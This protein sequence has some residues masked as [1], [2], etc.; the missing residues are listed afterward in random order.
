MSRTAVVIF[1]LGGPD[2]LEA[3][4]P[5]LFN[6][7]NDPLIIRQPGPIRWLI[8]KLISSRRAPIAREIYQHIGGRSPIL[9]ET[10]RQ[11]DA[12]QDALGDE[13]EYRVFIG[14]RYWKPFAQDCA[15]EVKEYGP[16]RTILLPLY[17]QFSTSTTQSFQEVW[18]KVAAQNGLTC[19]LS[20]ICCYPTEAG[21][22]DAMVELT[23][24]SLAKVTQKPNRVLF[25]A[26]GLPQKFV[27]AGDPYQAQVEMTVAAIVD[28]LEI[29]DLDYVICYQSRVGPVEW[30]RP[31]T[32]DEIKRAGA[33]G[34]SLTVIPVAFVS[35]HSETLVEL[36]IEYGKL[37]KEVGVPEYIRS[38][39]V[40]VN[41]RFIDGLAG[42]V[43]SAETSGVASATGQK[44]CP[45]G[46]GACTYC[47]TGN[48]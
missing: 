27:A 16:D 37:A 38:P 13:S 44:I 8:A 47:L 35:E 11:A 33:D 20:T 36:D 30:L 3:V 7:F 26:H 14:M 10:Q 17:P 43:K 32:D 34:L 39:T 19:P 9:E 48:A 40:G 6:L 46:F 15:A 28:R 18:S 42:L 2:S 29:P 41:Q 4:Q 25:S 24:S 45:D 23:R 1:N 21:F 12:L 31:Y 22:I 5:F